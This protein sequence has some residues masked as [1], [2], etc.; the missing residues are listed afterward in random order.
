MRSAPCAR[1]K[2]RHA[3]KAWRLA[4]I[5]VKTASSTRFL[6]SDQAEDR[7]YIDGTNAYAVLRGPGAAATA[8]RRSARRAGDRS[9]P[10]NEQDDGN[11][12]WRRKAR[13]P[14]P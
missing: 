4:W 1:T 11:G 8:T 14:L 5:S 2:S 12:W 9:I 6:R 7:D 3:A 10:R 13:A